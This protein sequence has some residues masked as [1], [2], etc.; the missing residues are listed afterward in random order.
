MP[1]LFGTT[2]LHPYNHQGLE[3]PL[4]DLNNSPPLWDDPV[5]SFSQQ[6][7]LLFPKA[8]WRPIIAKVFKHHCQIRITH[9]RC[10][11]IRP[12]VF[13]SQCQHFFQQ[14]L[15]HPI[16]AK[17]LKHQCQIRIPSSRC[18]MIRSEVFLIRMPALFPTALAPL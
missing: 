5:R 16:I 12:E 14:R 8:L 6:K 13:L 18:G 15:W 4:P 11:M 17:V 9:R 7:L 1:A 2:F 10:G 3:A